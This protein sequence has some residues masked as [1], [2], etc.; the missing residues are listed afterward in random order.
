M[1]VGPWV[2]INSPTR[3]AVEI[4]NRYL[5][6]SREKYNTNAAPVHTGRNFSTISI[7]LLIDIIQNGT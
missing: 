6:F 1:P 4:M 3:F 2:H 7:T 5:C